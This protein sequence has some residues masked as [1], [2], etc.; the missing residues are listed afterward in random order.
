MRWWQNLF[1]AKARA[2]PKYSGDGY[3]F[4]EWFEPRNIFELQRADGLASNETIF[5]AVTRLS[6][7]MA[8]LPLKLRR[9][10]QEVDNDLSGL[11]TVQPNA[12]MSSFDFIRVLETHRNTAGNGYALKMYDE[13]YQLESLHVLEPSKVEPVIEK[14]TG[15][16]WYEVRGDSGRYYVH[17]LDMLHVRHIYDGTVYKG[18]SPIRV[19]RGTTE[20]DRSVRKFTLDSLDGAITASFI[21]GMGTNLADEKK[22]ATLKAF[23]EFYRQ[24][25]GL[26][27]KEAGVEIEPIKREFIDTK[28]F[29]A[30]RITRSRVAVVFNLPV[31]M[32]GESEG[33][34]YSSMEQSWLDFCTFSLAPIVRHYEQELDRKLLTAADR[35]RGL[36]FKFNLNALARAD[37]RARGEFYFKGV[38]SGW[39]TPNEVRAWEELPPQPG[40]DDLYMSGD[41]K[42]MAGRDG[43]DE[44]KR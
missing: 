4:R 1:R 19:L 8:S 5:S 9:K 11:V 16:L 39:F 31:H 3:D 6:N 29:E 34:S 35:G 17:N 12:S 23:R 37:M 21:L 14:G 13:R 18:V 27:I 2:E 26:L 24:N 43:L 20:F 15:D 42:P 30:E 44:R 38:R 22:A 32:L 10:F 7:A 33:I 41:L 40:G 36:E 28:A 25:G